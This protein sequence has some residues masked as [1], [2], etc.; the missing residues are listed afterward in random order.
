MASTSSKVQVD[1]ALFE[2]IDRL[3][4]VPRPSSHKPVRIEL[5]APGNVRFA[6]GNIPGVICE[7][8]QTIPRSNDGNG[9]PEI[10]QEGP[11]AKCRKQQSMKNGRFKCKFK[12]GKLMKLRMGLK[13]RLNATLSQAVARGVDLLS[14][15]LSL[16]GWRQ[17]SDTALLGRTVSHVT[18]GAEGGTDI[19]GRCQTKTRPSVLDVEST[20]AYPEEVPAAGTHP[21]TSA[22]SSKIHLKYICPTI[23]LLSIYLSIEKG[24]WMVKH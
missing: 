10:E 23:I 15:E 18:H 2:K 21:N 17:I 3:N 24:F 8:R 22:L 20:S 9:R 11:F 5:I 19:G 7:R 6:T 13:L 16:N 12:V 1:V 4:Q 14:N